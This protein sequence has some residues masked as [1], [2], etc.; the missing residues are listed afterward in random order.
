MFE[1]GAERWVGITTM[2]GLR[3]HARCHSYFCCF[4]YAALPPQLSFPLQFVHCS[5]RCSWTVIRSVPVARA[6]N[7]PKAVWAPPSHP[8]ASLV[9]LSF[10]RKQ[11]I[12][13][14]MHPA[15]SR[16]PG[17]VFRWRGG[18]FNSTLLPV[19]LRSGDPAEMRSQNSRT[20]E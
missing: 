12:E 19:V 8:T 13:N 3:S 15:Y 5:L 17:Y 16:N 7:V 14:K 11:Q 6:L 4:L 20:R 10:P 1:A 2:L 18:A 9:L